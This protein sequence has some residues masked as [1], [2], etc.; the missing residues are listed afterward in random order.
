MLEL[1]RDKDWGRLPELE[2]RCSAIVDRLRVI[3]STGTLEVVEVERVLY[4]L[5]RIRVEQTEVSDLIK[6]QL[7]ELISRMGYLSQQ[8][9]L[10]RAYGL[11]H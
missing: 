7:D 9:N 6:P 5:D 11:T 2:A 1:A 8:K 10:G 3:E 4:L